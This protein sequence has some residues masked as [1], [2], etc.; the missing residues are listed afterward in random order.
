MTT[1]FDPEEK[2]KHMQPKPLTQKEKN[3]LWFQIEEKIRAKEGAWLASPIP[4]FFTTFGKRLA[5]ATLAAL[6]LVSG[7]IT[8]A[9]VA[10]AAKPGDFFFP[11]DIAVEKIQ[12]I[13]SVGT[14][15]DNLRIRFAE[16]RLDEA[17]LVLNIFLEEAEAFEDTTNGTATS[18]PT[19]TVTSTTTPATNGTSTSTPEDTATSTDPDNGTTT[20]P[21]NDEDEDHNS[22]NIERAQNALAIAL[23]HL[24]NTRQKLEERGNTA[25]LAVIDDMI[26][27]LTKLAEEHLDKLNKFEAK[28][29]DNGKKL[30]VEIKA[31]SEEIKTK[32]KFEEKKDK[33]GDGDGDGKIKIKLEDKNSKT[34][35]KIKDD[36]TEIKF[37]FE[38]KKDKDDDDNDEDDDKGKNDK[39]GKKDKDDKKI[40][41]C[42][43]PPGNHDNSHTIQ[44]SKSAKNAHLAHGDTL[45][46]CEDGD[47]DDDNATSTP[48]IIAPII[49]DVSSSAGT[50]TADIIW[51]TDEGSDSKVFY[52][53]ATPLEIS[54]TTPSKTSGGLVTS[55]GISLDNLT[56]STTHYFIAVSADE[57]GNT[58]TSSEFSFTT[59]SDVIPE[60]EDT[61]PPVLSGITAT[62]TTAVSASIL[63]N[64]D[65]EASSKVWYGTSTPLS[66]E[67]LTLRESNSSFLLDHSFTLSGL[68]ASTTHYYLVTSSDAA[69]NTATSTEFSFFTLPE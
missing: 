26:A 21:T 18:T 35:L 37:K 32:F 13:F 31:S 63:W 42:H 40:T 54:S 50:T 62:S 58:A 3:T 33:D 46:E 22:R 56:A 44:V 29:K 60:P 14:G 38:V 11:I 51:N 36:E 34:E 27:E 9:R 52:G 7:S 68:T 30:K 47:E 25:A 48:D 4:G 24:E 59:L 6:I 20:P 67:P 8:T 5:Y 1:P 2:L 43:I 41:I 39:K 19:S 66:I 17:K 15:K 53:T 16:E 45:G 65:E 61:T 12:L 55:H 49:S 57:A 28:I 10:D 69:G 23:E 64:T